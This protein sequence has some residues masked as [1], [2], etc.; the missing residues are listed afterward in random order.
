M[1]PPLGRDRVRGRGDDDGTS[2]AAEVA[3]DFA[4]TADTSVVAATAPAADADSSIA[5]EAPVKK[6]GGMM[7]ENNNRKR[8][9]NKA[10]KERKAFSIKR[11]LE[12]LA[13][14]RLKVDSQKVIIQRVGTSRSAVNRWKRDENEMAKQME[15]ECRGA[16]K[17]QLKTDGLR[18]VKDGLRKFRDLN[19]AMPKCLRTPLTRE[20][21]SC[22][23]LV[24]FPPP[25]IAIECMYY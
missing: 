17:R 4:A 2:D 16:F 6:L 1:E 3:I 7:D 8:Q 20:Y 9:P 14:I 15:E 19:D 10:K 11:K 18:R 21:H 23:C 12:I 5:V 22:I 25:L 13:E 24:R